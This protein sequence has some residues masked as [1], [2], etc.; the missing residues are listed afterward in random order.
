M[1]NRKFPAKKA[2]LATF[3]VV[4]AVWLIYAAAFSKKAAVN[5]VVATVGNIVQQVSVTGNVA[6]AE[7]VDLAFETSG[8]I[9]K[10][11]ADVGDKVSAGQ[12]LAKLDT[13]EL[14]TILAKARADMAA[15][16]SDL[17]KA[18]VILANYYASVSD[19][20][21]DAYT[22]T[23][24]A[25]K[26]QT[27]PMFTNVYT[28]PQ[29]TFMTTNSQETT[30]AQSQRM[31]INAILSGLFGEVNLLNKSSASDAIEATVADAQSKL[32]AI[33]GFLDLLAQAL[34]DSIS[35]SATTIG[36]YKTSLTAARAEINTALANINDQ[37]QNIAVQKAAT[38]SDEAAIE[39]SRAAIAN[40]Q[41]QL[42]KTALYAPIGG[43]ITRED[44]KV[45]EIATANATLIS[46][47]TASDLEVEADIPEADIAKVKI[48]NPAAITL[49]AYGNDVV[50]NA[51]VTSID[52]AE[53]MIEGVAT[54][55][56][57]FQFVENDSRPKSGMTANIDV[58]T[59]KHENVIVV[60]QRAV[61]AK[62]NGKFVLLD[63]G[64]PQKPE[65]RAVI[66]GLRGPAGNVE[67]T[68]GLKEGEKVIIPTLQ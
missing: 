19:I 21:N 30:N 39:S 35:L 55:K 16:Q 59:D 1:P 61:M 26:T 31:Q 8:K 12:I 65:E 50:F 67:I 47:I 46:I 44:A 22:K 17:N 29:L 58:I 52:P 23:N 15:Q 32:V 18:Q 40:I 64:N 38:A 33:R 25:I 28:N 53:T 48:G 14:S 3:A 54:Y 49:D 66:T 2:A 11:Y 6:P 27:D 4:I 56:T 9:A 10:V 37:E 43:T 5:E 42:D 13:A 68:S 34:S 24:D 57:K 36:T 63:N 20:L 41:A 45:G 51:K 62:T 7:N 60:P